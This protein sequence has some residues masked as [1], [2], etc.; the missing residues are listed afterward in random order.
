M[1]MAKKPVDFMI[2]DENHESPALTAEEEAAVGRAE[3]DEK[4][5]RLHSHDD[6]AK[7]LRER[8]ADI[9]KR[10]RKSVNLS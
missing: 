4:A 6:I 10:A 2:D 7:W 1:A 8:A 3:A 5:G 9:V